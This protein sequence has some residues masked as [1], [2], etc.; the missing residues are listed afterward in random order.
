ME[1]PV[2]E[3]QESTGCLWLAGLFC[4]CGPIL[5]AIVLYITQ[6]NDAQLSLFLMGFAILTPAIVGLDLICALATSIFALVVMKRKGAGFALLAVAL[7]NGVVLAY[8]LRRI[9]G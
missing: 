7:A 2:N 6:S 8:I 3:N 1:L 5:T 4:A 9:H